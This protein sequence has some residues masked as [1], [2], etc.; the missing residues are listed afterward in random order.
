VAPSSIEHHSKI[1]NNTQVSQPGFQAP[2]P[3]AQK[4]SPGPDVVLT[5]SSGEWDRPGLDGRRAPLGE[6]STN[7][8]ASTRIVVCGLTGLLFPSG[9]ASAQTPQDHQITPWRHNRAAA[10]TLTFDDGVPSQVNDAVPL[11]NERGLKASFFVIPS[12]V[13]DEF[14]GFD[15]T[16]DQWRQVAAFGHE[17]GSQ[18]FTD[19]DL[20]TLSD[21]QLRFEL[22]ESQRVINEQIP[23]QACVSLIYPFGVSDPHVQAVASEYYVS[24]RG[25]WAGEEAGT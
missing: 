15:V 18:T 14:N 4:F 5:G 23:S 3:D 9:I 7:V 19:P 8:K 20:T 6:E 16:W 17:I 11:L 10:V 2:V 21:S 22:S 25:S 24:A 13:P 1:G 12:V